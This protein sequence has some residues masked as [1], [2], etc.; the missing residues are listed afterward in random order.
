[1]KSK[2]TKLGALVFCALIALFCVFGVTSVDNVAYAFNESTEGWEEGV[3]TSL[4]YGIYWYQKGQ[5]VPVKWD[6]ENV[7]FDS[8]RPTVIFTHGMKQNE[9]YYCRDILSAYE[10]TREYMAS[11]GVDYNTEYYDYYID[12]GYNVGH[13]YWNQLSEENMFGDVK[14]WSSD[15]DI[16]MRYFVSDETGK[17]VQGDENLNPTK[18]V[19][20]LYA[21]NI[22]SALGENFSGSLQLIGHSMGG[23]LSL[24]VTEN[25]VMMCDDGKIGENLVPDRVTLL[26][27]Y[28][29]VSSVKGH[30][31]HRGGEDANGKTIAELCSEAVIT[32]AEHGIGIDGYGAGAVIYT[33]Y[34]SPMGQMA[35]KNNPEIIDLLTE[36]F[37]DNCVWIHLDALDK[38]YGMTKTHCVVPDYYFLSLYQ[39]KSV[40]NFG[41]S[42]P[43]ALSTADEIYALRGRAYSQKLSNK[44]KAQSY[45]SADST[46]TR[47]DRNKNEVNLIVNVTSE[48]V[49]GIAVYNAEGELVYSRNSDYS[50]NRIE[51]GLDAGE[52]RIEYSNLCDEVGKVQTATVTEDECEILEMSES[53]TAE[54]EEKSFVWLYALLGVLGTITV[55]FGAVCVVLIT[56]K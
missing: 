9:G 7:N 39:E 41:D 6:S 53:F 4:D 54:N 26:D 43:G 42:V 36:R 38:V 52:Y 40:D 29:S 56:R 2:I 22:I 51:V 35:Y 21:E 24:A 49:Y 33:Q 30:I 50:I 44:K 14:I 45:L 25:L 19:S 23:D 27:P 15:T 10:D 8:S 11:A 46:F 18:S 3:F 32:L 20:V 48:D 47:V 55:A 28:F 31:D 37:S 13:F 1:M 12:L 5:E 16:G 34:S 17:R